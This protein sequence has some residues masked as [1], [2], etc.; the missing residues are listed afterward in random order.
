[1]LVAGASSQN[2][3]LTSD[4]EALV[5]LHLEE[6]IR[7]RAFSG[8]KRAQD[9]LRL[10][11]EHTLAGETDSLRERMIGAEMFNRPVDYDTA[12]DSVVRVK[13][14]ELR[15]K[16]IQAYAELKDNSRVRIEVPPGTYVP[17]FIF[18]ADEA[19]STSV[20]ND[21]QLTS[22]TAVKVELR[23]SPEN[24]PTERPALA[25]N[26]ARSENI[27]RRIG[28][29]AI[30]VCIA[31]ILVVAG[32]RVW[33]GRANAKTEI[34]SIAVLP[35]ENLSGDLRQEYFADG[36]TEELIA[37][38]G[39]MSALHVISRTSAMSF[40]GSRKG[41]PEIARELSVD[42][43]VEGS[44]LRDGSQVRITARLIDAKTDRPIW[45]ENFTRGSTDVL[46]SEGEL[47]QSIANQLS[48][49]IS[50]QTQ[51]HLARSAS[52]SMEAEDLYLQGML[53][54]HSGNCENAMGYF[55]KAVQA[56]SRFANAYA[57]LAN[58]YGLLGSG[59]W[60]PYAEAFSNEK[61]NAQLAVTYDDSLSE[62]H[63]QLADA[64]FNADWDLA[65]ADAEF[66]KALA[67]NPNSARVH[68]QYGDYLD[69][70]GNPG[71]AIDEA[72]IAVKLDPLSGRALSDLAYIYY[73][74]REYDQALSLLKLAES[75]EPNLHPDIF[76]YGDVYV[77]KGM[78]RE[79]INEFLKLGD[80]PHALGHLGNAY[81]RAGQASPARKIIATLQERVAKDQLGAYE[82]ALVYTGLGEKDQ[83]FVWL[84]IALETRDRGM[85]FLQI[86]PPLDPLRS[87]PRFNQILHRAGLPNSQ[88]VRVVA[89]PNR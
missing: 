77:E 70:T 41:L 7:S 3:Q 59:G 69:L 86:D 80:N 85:H 37:D 28:I 58:C 75:K 14:T 15:K 1:M 4:Q 54:F 26:P 45:G 29:L 56:D 35:F 25:L 87:D 61:S 18:R 52:I 40:K 81:A 31:A 44:V 9:F 50:P 88:S 5:R 32:V 33:H 55:E 83:A 6:L 27:G 36:V 16:L 47:A 23:I 46:A 79:A 12:N 66:H 74:S 17:R 10:I 60:M 30:A 34:R 72:R 24:P 19:S 84:Q 76:A 13:A 20:A 2:Q 78:Y 42:G 8:G 38:L 62:G 53:N 71:S 49:T 89:T 73:F 21:V 11:V 51:A 65:G 64:L 63:A 57:A 68:D 43:V 67:L 22:P 82:I 39:Q 48:L